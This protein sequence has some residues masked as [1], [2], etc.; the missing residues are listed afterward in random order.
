MVLAHLICLVK[1]WSL[2]DLTSFLAKHPEWLRCLHLKNVPGESTWSKLLDRVPKEGLEQ[3]LSNLVQDL[4][5]KRFLA[6]RVFA[7]DGSFLPACR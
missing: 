3:L 4:H 1:Q 5:A 6:F 7:A 2:E